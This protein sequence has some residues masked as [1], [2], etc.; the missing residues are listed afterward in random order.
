MYSWKDVHVYYTKCLEAEG[1]GVNVFSK[2]KVYF[3]VC[4]PVL[5]ATFKLSPCNN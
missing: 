3:K 2:L 1:V 5:M 4:P